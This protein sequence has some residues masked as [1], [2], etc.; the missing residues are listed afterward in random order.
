MLAV[1]DL[2][3]IGKITQPWVGTKAGPATV[4]AA[5]TS[6]DRTNFVDSGAKRSLSRTF[7]IPGA[8]LPTRFG[9]TETYG[10]FAN[11]TEAQAFINGVRKKMANCKKSDLGAEVTDKREQ[12]SG[13]YGS[14]WTMWRVTSKISDEKSITYWMGVTRIDNVVAQVGFVPANDDDITA[15]TF[16]AL[17]VR[18]RDRLLELD[19]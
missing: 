7:L 16:Q 15:D 12:L 17:I 19:R 6:C 18:A 13:P 8:D 9:I 3:P 11:I 14:E 10:Q 4:N 1:A 5:A 2:P